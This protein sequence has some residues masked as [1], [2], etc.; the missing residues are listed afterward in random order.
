MQSTAWQWENI[1]R[2]CSNIICIKKALINVL[3]GFDLRGGRPLK[4]RNQFFIQHLLVNGL[5]S[6]RPDW[7]RFVIAYYWTVSCN[8]SSVLSNLFK[9]TNWTARTTATWT[10]LMLLQYRCTFWM[11]QWLQVFL[12]R[13]SICNWL[14]LF[15]SHGVNFKHIHCWT[16]CNGWSC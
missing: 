3:H 13:L 2:L 5:E 7:V 6:L 10:M 12:K 4:D 11:K 1:H 9:R 8:W 14:N 15:L 16:S